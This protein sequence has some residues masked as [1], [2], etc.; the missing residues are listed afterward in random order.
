ME[1][2]DF[3]LKLKGMT[4]KVWAGNIEAAITQL[5]RRMNTEG[6]NKELRKRKHY[7]PQSILRRQKLAEAKLRW[8]KKHAQI[9]E[10][11]P[12]K[13]PKKDKRGDKKPVSKDPI[14]TSPA[15]MKF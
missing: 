5:K 9:F 13:K 4:V 11:E 8:R 3:V 12:P 14:N 15:V 1:S 6:I 2:D 7:T 10:L